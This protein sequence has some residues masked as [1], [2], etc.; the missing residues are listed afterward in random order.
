MSHPDIKCLLFFLKNT[1][2]SAFEGENEKVKSLKLFHIIK[3]FF[4]A[5]EFQ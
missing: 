1:K 5:P 2:K 4:Y 3:C